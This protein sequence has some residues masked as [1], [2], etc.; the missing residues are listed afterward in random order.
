MKTFYASIKIFFWLFKKPI[1]AL[2]FLIIASFMIIVSIPI[3]INDYNKSLEASLVSKQPHILVEYMSE[4][5]ILP[6]E[7]IQKISNKLLVTV[8]EEEL[9][10]INAYVQEKIFVEFKKYGTNLSQYNGFVKAIGLSS[11]TYPNVYDFS[12]FEPL[13]L[14]EYGF[15]IT[16]LEMFEEFKNTKNTVFFNKSLYGAVEPLVTYEASFDMKYFLETKVHETNGNLFG[17]VEDFFTQPIIYMN[18][19]FLNEILE[20]DSEHISGFMLNIKNQEKLETIKKQLENY[21]NKD[22]KIVIVRSWRDI[23]KKQNNIFKIFTYVGKFLEWILLMLSV[24]AVTMFMYKSLLLKQPEFRLLN[25]IGLRLIKITNIS[26]ILVSAVAVAMSVLLSYQFLPFLYQ[27]F[28]HKSLDIKM[29]FYIYDL[30]G[31]YLFLVL[32][33]L[34]M[35]NSLF[36]Q[37]YNIFK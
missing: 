19:D 31:A 4:N 2:V 6:R 10:T 12:L 34:Y 37:K 20:K 14:D 11:A 30:L 13:M 8:G 26:F 32:V 23:N 1:V 17:V 18:M 33:V 15:K 7:E 35:V 24:F 9:E 29:N 3:V 22:K 27:V 21:F 36:N 5:Y 25:I 16:G 28:I